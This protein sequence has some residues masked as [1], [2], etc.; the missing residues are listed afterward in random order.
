LPKYKDK[1]HGRNLLIYTIQA[2]SKLAL[3]RGIMHPSGLPIEI[4]TCQ[5]HVDGVRI[6]P[7]TGYYVVEVVYE[8]PAIQADVDAS[9]S[10]G[11]D[12]GINALTALTSNYVGF[13]PRI[14]NGRPVKSINQDDN[15]E[16]ARL[17]SLLKGK[18]PNWKQEVNIGKHEVYAGKRIKRGLFRSHN[19]QCIHADVN[20][21][22]NI[23]RKVE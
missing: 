11:I 21:S 22:L 8:E 2:I 17:P 9:L 7:R 18:N 16:R 10:A 5:M 20:G 3:R 13:V 6:V 1:Q 15:K 19:G 14:V 23:I 12:M 4:Q